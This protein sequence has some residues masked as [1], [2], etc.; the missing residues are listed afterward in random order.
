M[1][2]ASV[3]GTED[4]RFESCQGRNLFASLFF[5]STDVHASRKETPENLSYDSFLAKQILLDH[6]D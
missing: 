5:N 4:C 2:N 3:Y 1:D 6:Y